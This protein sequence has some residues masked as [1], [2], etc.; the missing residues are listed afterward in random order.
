MLQDNAH[1]NMVCAKKYKSKQTKLLIT[2]NE[3]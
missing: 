1:I 2:D 3:I